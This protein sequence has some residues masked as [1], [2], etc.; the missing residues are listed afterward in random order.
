MIQHSHNPEVRKAV[1]DAVAL[2]LRVECGEEEADE[3]ED[4]LALMQQ[5]KSG[6]IHGRPRQVFQKDPNTRTDIQYG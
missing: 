3:V 2:V 5:W 4:L 6:T 1:A